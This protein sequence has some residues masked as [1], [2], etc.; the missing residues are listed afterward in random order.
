MQKK[1]APEPPLN[2]G[3]SPLLPS[4]PP[5]AR[6]II[7]VGAVVFNG[8]KILLIKRGKPPREDEWSL[9]GGK[10]EL[11]ECTIDTMIRE[12]LEETGLNV[13]P[14]PLLD[15]IDFI[16]RTDDTIN[17]HYT[18]IDYLAETTDNQPRAGSDA[19]DA[20]FFTLDEALKLTLWSE[21][22]RVILLGAQKKGLVGPDDLP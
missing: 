12:V 3:N 15:V 18:L 6:P 22:K 2:D 17:F 20:R 5:A 16:E 8:D 4:S 11:G 1:T 19:K 10:Q 7:G 21:T 9:P 13:I 14:G